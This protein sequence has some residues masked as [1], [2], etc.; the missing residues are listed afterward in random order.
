MSRLLS[1]NV[2][3]LKKDHCFRGCMVFMAVFGGAMVFFAYYAKC[4]N[5][6]E[7]PLESLC[8]DFANV[9]G[10]LIAAFVSLFQ[11]T[12]Y[13]DGTIKNKLIVGHRREEVYFA[14]LL[15][16]MTAVLCLNLVY[17]M[18]VVLCGIP[19]LGFFQVMDTSALTILAGL[20]VLMDLAFTAVFTMFSMLNQNK[21]AVATV[22]IISA[23]V[24]LFASG[25]I[26]SRL[27]EPRIYEA[28]QEVTDK[29][30][31]ITH[32]ETENPYYLEGS[33]RMVFSF[34]KDFLPSGQALQI[35]QMQ[36]E[37][38]GRRAACACVLIALSSGMGFLCF[39]RKDIR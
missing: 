16:N 5:G 19:V 34:W 31:V 7:V 23:M 22:S 39:F 3:R 27:E 14:A 26:Q 33:G 4:K 38:A 21:A 37:H 11:G 28:F 15:A 29:G 24:L 17:V 9:M 2:A 10:I 35:E 8:F 6:Y 1:A 30:Y 32:E 20:T 13:S 25:Y 36:L 18:V 12:E